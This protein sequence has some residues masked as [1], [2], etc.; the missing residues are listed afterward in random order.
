MALFIIQQLYISNYLIACI[1]YI[2]PWKT[3]LGSTSILEDFFLHLKEACNSING[4]TI[5]ATFQKCKI[6]ENL[7]QKP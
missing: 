2:A 3:V 7:R 4:M 5:S 6:P 1:L